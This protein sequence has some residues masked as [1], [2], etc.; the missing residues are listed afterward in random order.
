M[1]VVYKEAVNRVALR[2]SH[3]ECMTLK[4]NILDYSFNAR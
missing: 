1:C 2:P 4:Q 3:N